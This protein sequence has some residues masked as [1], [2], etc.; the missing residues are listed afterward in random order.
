M[1]VFPDGRVQPADAAEYLGRKKKTLDEWRSRGTGPRFVRVQGRIFYFVR[2][3]DEF[4]AQSA[5]TST[6][7]ARQ[8]DTR[9]R[10]ERQA[11]L[12]AAG[13]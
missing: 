13:V 9:R 10:A 11:E 12:A 5:A 1:M 4:I 3:L 2:D 8:N 6:A 7:Q